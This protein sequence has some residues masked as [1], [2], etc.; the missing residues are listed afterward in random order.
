MPPP[1]LEPSANSAPP[2]AP[3][4]SRM[5]ESLVDVS[6]STVT[7]LKVLSVTR[8]SAGWST[9][10]SMGASVVMKASSVAMSGWSIPAP[11]AV[12]PMV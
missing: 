1:Q 4:A 3:L 9:V 11:L 6:P 2:A 10:A 8:D 12:P 7:Q 5:H